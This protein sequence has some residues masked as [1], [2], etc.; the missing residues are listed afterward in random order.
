MRTETR[1]QTR[2]EK[3]TRA[4]STAVKSFPIKRLLGEETPFKSGEVV[5]YV[6]LQT[7]LNK[8]GTAPH[9]KLI[10]CPDFSILE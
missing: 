4:E 6:F 3:S 7:F 1:K 5:S 9:V 10:R 8:K 2:M